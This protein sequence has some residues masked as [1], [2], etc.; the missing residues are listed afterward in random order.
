MLLAIE[1]ET[2]GVITANKTNYIIDKRLSKDIFQFPHTIYFQ[3]FCMCFYPITPILLARLANCH[4][5]TDSAVEQSLTD[6]TN[7]ISQWGERGG[8]GPGFHMTTNAK[9]QVSRYKGVCSPVRCV[10]LSMLASE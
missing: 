7:G 4:A 10:D 2:D 6:Q 8:E 3:T 1:I 9:R 5:D